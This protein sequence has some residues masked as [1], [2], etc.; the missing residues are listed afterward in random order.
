MIISEAIENLFNL[1][2]LNN[3]Y[4][5]E[6][7][8][9]HFDS[10]IEVSIS[11]LGY[12]EENRLNCP[13]D[14]TKLKVETIFKYQELG[15]NIFYND[16][17][18]EDLYFLINMYNSKLKL[19]QS[20]KMNLSLS[21]I[22]KPLEIIIKRMKRNPKKYA[23]IL[24]DSSLFDSPFNNKHQDK[25]NESADLIEKLKQEEIATNVP[26]LTWEQRT[27]AEKFIDQ[28]VNDFFKI[29]GIGE[30]GDIDLSEIKNL[31]NRNDL[32]DYN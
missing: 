6:K 9:I 28:Y 12:I 5:V 15:Y 17:Y 23:H 22:Q 32:P 2:N 13:V 18:L 1:N 3:V 27:A 20:K 4:E 30:P 7:L 29:N 31:K 21:P 26:E 16:K 25:Q 24:N 14:R 10:V 19:D 8:R 11:T